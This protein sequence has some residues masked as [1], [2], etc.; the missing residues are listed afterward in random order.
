MP[1]PACWPHPPPCLLLTLPLTLLRGLP[2]GAEEELQ[3][4]QPET[5]VS[6]A[7]GETA[8]LNCTVTSMLPVGPILWFR[9][10]G[11]GRE[12]IYNLKEGSLSSQVT[13]VADTSRRDNMDF[14]IRI[15][16]VTPA[17]TGMYYC[18][19]FRRG[20][21][22]TELRSG[23]GTQLTMSGEYSVGLRSL[24]CVNSQNIVLK[25]F[26]DGNELPASQ[27]TV[28]PEGDSPSYSISSTAKVVLAPGDVRSQVIYQVA[29]DTLKGDTTL[30]GTANLSE[31]IR[32]SE[33]LPF[34]VSVP[35]T[36]EVTQHLMAGGEVN[37]CQVKNFY[38]LHLKL[39]WLENG[40]TSRTETASTVIKN[41]D[42]TF[43][44]SSW[45]LVNLSAHREDV[46]L[47]C[48][49][50][51]D[52][53][54]AVST[55]LTLEASAHERDQDK[56]PVLC[57]P[58]LVAVLLGLKVLLVAVSAICVHR[59][60]TAQRWGF[61]PRTE[62]IRAAQH[63]FAQSSS[64]ASRMPVP[65]SW[66]RPP[67]CLLLTLLLTLLRGLPAGAEEELQVVQP[68]KSVTVVAG[69][70]AILT[71][72]VTSL[73]P[74]GPTKWFRGTGS[75][76]ELIYSLKEGSLSPRVTAAT[77][78][79]RR[80]NMDFSIRISNITPADTGMYYCVKFRRGSPDTELRS[81]AGTQLTVSAKPS[82]P[83]VSRPTGRFTPGQTVSFT[84]ESHGFSPKKITL[85]WFKDGNEL[86]ASQTT[87]DPEGDS[88]SYSI[89][90]TAKVVLAPGDVRSQVICQ[91]A[92]DTLKGDTTLRGTANLSETIRVPPT[93]EVTQHTVSGNQENVTC[94]VKN[95]YPQHLQLT[96]L[97]NGNKSRTETASTRVENP[98]GTFSWSSWLLVN[99]SAHRE[100]VMLTW[101]V[102]H[103]GQPAVST[104]L[105]VKASAHQRDQS[106]DGPSAKPS[107]PVVSGPTGR[108]TPG[109]TV[110]FTCESHGFSPRNIVL[111]WFKD[112]NELPASQ[113]TVDPE[114]DSPSYSISSTAKVVLA[115]GD[116]RS[117]VI[118]QVAHDTLKGDTTLRGT[119]NLSETIRVPPTLEA[120]QHLMAGGEVNTCQVKNFYPLHLKLTWLE[121]GNTSRTETASTVI[122]NQDGTFG[123]SSWLL[124]NLSAHREDV[125]LTCLVEHDGQPAVST[126]LTLEASAHERDQDKVPPTLEATQHLMA[127]SEVNT[128][129]V[130]NFYP[131]HLKLT[132]L[133]NGNTSRTET[134]STVIKNQDGTFGWSSWLLVNLSAHREDVRLTCLV[135][136][137]GQPAVSTNL[138]LEASAPQKDQ[139]KGG[140]SQQMPG[141]T[142]LC[143]PRGSPEDRDLESEQ[144][145]QVTMSGHHT[146]LLCPQ[147]CP[148]LCT[149]F[150]VA[151]LLGL[152]VLLVIAVSAICVHRKRTAQ[153]IF[154]KKRIPQRDSYFLGSMWGPVRGHNSRPPHSPRDTGQPSSDWYKRHRQDQ[155]ANK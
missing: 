126:N 103:D 10:T 25:W 125:M 51:H 152:K 66:P 13:A 29:H 4:I 67:P 137:D 90:S 124:V 16:N 85:K 58:F 50:E 15:S 106:T 11:P 120:T 121:N 151:V 91:V 100:D 20:S 39:T 119:A 134:A 56:G 64:S 123:W 115:P 74:V 71:C 76:R 140:S 21:P 26:K 37:T 80:E 28:D 41:Q 86:P 98:D 19:K 113:T 45:L 84:C 78:T 143:S 148:V 82:S 107:L 40:N 53:Q 22:D 136:H 146:G 96:W 43:G 132:W 36:L 97:E 27:T 12:L 32:G 94:L 47:T 89:S 70:T 60:R 44:W 57:T 72:S 144:G 133:Q 92:H 14:S 122:K 142:A 1:V 153:Q 69:E 63:T 99:L 147:T 130:K 139:H 131:L 114:G 31:T 42:G 135:E 75:G 34:A 61:S 154:L 112:G 65:A 73:S 155:R 110:S 102:E 127:G 104:N 149:P 105:T 141:P 128:C 35:P 5:S 101:L 79:T 24:V 23:A 59:K 7:A 6:I 9:G 81:G 111:K 118:Y 68:E 87:V 83:V 30:R 18:V 77:D 62:Q 138:T 93:L 33:L 46:M 48:L 108:F 49:V 17:D 109:Q 95:F 129:Q 2:A 38:P 117:Q 150:L 8:T 3:V 145:T 116:V 55:N 52:G 88:P 54:P